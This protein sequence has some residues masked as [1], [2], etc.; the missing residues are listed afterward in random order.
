MSAA[1]PLCR[2]ETRRIH[3]RYDRTFADLPWQG[4]RVTIT[5]RARRFRCATVGCARKIFAERLGGAAAL[6]GRRTVRL[7]DVQRDLGLALGGA[8][9]ARLAHRLGLRVSGATLLRLVRR[10]PD[11]GRP[12][13]PPP[14]VIGI[15]DWA[16]KRGHRYG[17]VICDLERRRIIDLLPDRAASTVEAWL[18]ARPEIEIIARDRG[19]GY[20]HAASR[21]APHAVQVADRWHLIENASAAF[22]DAVRR[23]MRSI[24]DA[25]GSGSV[26]AGRLTCAERRQYDGFLRREQVATDISALVAAG[27]SIKEIARRTG[28]SRKVVRQALRGGRTDIFRV[29]STS[30]DAFLP[31]LE[32]EWAAG[33]HNG[34]E[35]WR[36]AKA[37]G[38]SGGLRVVSEWTTRR[39]RTDVT[40]GV[41][42][43]KP[44]SARYL[45]R[46][47]TT[48]RDHLSRCDAIVI[49]TI[50]RAV[51]MLVVARDLVDSFHSILR[52]H[53]ADALDAW[54]VQAST[55]LLASFA[56]GIVADHKAVAAAITE[57]WS[58][59]QT[60]G[61]ITK[62]KMIKRQMFGRAGL[63]LLRARLCAA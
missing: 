10:R 20:G 57:R 26:D 23:S 29:R 30:L 2:Q 47:M 42:P 28:H 11:D 12:R 54:I 32:A 25:L 56:A 22:L 39:R 52:A 13:P 62:L 4:R 48:G 19:G 16:W 27:A 49:D 55:G 17:T 36:R 15:D 6:H 5:V 45:A 14:R 51:P 21:A 8:G 43:G 31:R 41:L 40:P 61:Q 35:L 34:A 33:C 53:K 9:G 18:L 58:N 44:P 50:E 3:S 46:L 37:A 1:C 24:R 59:G 63:D 7:A 38:F 60:E